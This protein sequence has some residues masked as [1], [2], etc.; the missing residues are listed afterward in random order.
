M[1]RPLWRLGCLLMRYFVTKNDYL[2]N[3]SPNTDREDAAGQ[4]NVISWTIREKRNV[5]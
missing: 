1:L 5:E 2:Y 4:F 3:K